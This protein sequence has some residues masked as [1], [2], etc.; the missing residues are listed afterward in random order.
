MQVHASFIE[1]DGDEC[2]DLLRS[3]T[4]VLVS[5]DEE[6]GIAHLKGAAQRCIR[7]LEEAASMLRDAF[8]A[9]SR[10]THESQTHTILTLTVGASGMFEA[11]PTPKARP[12]KV[13]HAK[14]TDSDLAA[15]S[16]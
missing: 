14:M 8:R 15:I 9:T 3:G 11:R 7:S 6:R 16:E 13:A 2:F 1:I 5:D 12:A 4:A 10:G